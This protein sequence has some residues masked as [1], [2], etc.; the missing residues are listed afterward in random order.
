MICSCRWPLLTIAIRCLMVSTIVMLVVMLVVMLAV[1][2]SAYSEGACEKLRVAGS[3]DW[4]PIAYL[5]R[6]SRQPIGKAYHLVRRLG[7][8]IGLPVVIESS[9][10]WAR[11]MDL[12]RKGEIDIIA[13]LVSTPRRAEHLVF[14]RPFYRSTIHAFVH[15][16]N[17]IKIANAADLS[18]FLR[19]TIRGSSIG[20]KLDALLSTNVIFVNNESQQI[21]LVAARRAD[22]FVTSAAYFNRLQNRYPNTG[23][24][25]RLPTPID[26]LDVLIGISKASPCVHYLTQANQLI[27]KLY[28]QLQHPLPNGF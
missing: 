3:S 1:M 24:L 27:E 21:D 14:T 12:M 19:A 16:D 5:H 9:Y 20:K 7:E 26:T 18:Q 22:Y 13:G 4:V 11:M 2:V 6:E 15:P 28:P 17:K 23:K 25:K 10:P 8:D